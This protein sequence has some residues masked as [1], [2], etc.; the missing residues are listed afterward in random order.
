MIRT[1]LLGIRVIQL[2]DGVEAPIGIVVGI[3]YEADTEDRGASW[4]LL[5]LGDDGRVRSFNAEHEIRI[6]MDDWP[7]HLP[8]T[9]NGLAS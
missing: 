9:K 8:P 3:A 4:Q 2:V 5:V 1:N 6:D 7:K